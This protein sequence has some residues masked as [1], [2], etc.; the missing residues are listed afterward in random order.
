[1]E[2]TFKRLL[3][4]YRN[5]GQNLTDAERI[6][7]ENMIPALI[8]EAKKWLSDD[9]FVALHKK[10]KSNEERANLPAHSKRIE[11]M[12]DDGVLVSISPYKIG[13]KK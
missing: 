8:S 2:L 3:E 10:C 9:E 4:K 12:R 6:A 11:Y 1:M 7:A 13:E 5:D